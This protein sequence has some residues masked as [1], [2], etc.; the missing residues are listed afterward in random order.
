MDSRSYY[1]GNLLDDLQVVAGFEYLSELKE[2]K[3]REKVSNS[4]ET[5]DATAYSL[6]QWSIAIT[7]ILDAKIVFSTYEE[8]KKYINK[9]RI[10]F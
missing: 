5:I 10:A 7:Y 2:P 8:A 3:N 4:L 6:R 1:T 9:I